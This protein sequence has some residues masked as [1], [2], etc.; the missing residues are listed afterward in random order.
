MGVWQQLPAGFPRPLPPARVPA[1]PS[2]PPQD[3]AVWE[4]D[5]FD[6]TCQLDPPPPPPFPNQAGSPPL[7]A[8]C[9]QCR[10][11]R[12]GSLTAGVWTC[13]PRWPCWQRRLAAAAFG[14]EWTA[15]ACSARLPVPRCQQASNAGWVQARGGGCILGMVVGGSQPCESCHAGLACSVF[16]RCSPPAL[17]RPGRPPD[18]R[19]H[20]PD[21]GGAAAGG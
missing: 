13:P 11:R 10:M 14:L 8:P 6:S 19:H 9:P 2:A 1:L 7:P 21:R 4:F 3:E 5:S 16:P 15:A 17:P 12:C 20:V 18:G